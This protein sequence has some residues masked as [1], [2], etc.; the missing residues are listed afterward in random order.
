MALDWLELFDPFQV[1]LLIKIDIVIQQD[2]LSADN[3]VKRDAQ[4]A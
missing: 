3:H 4:D 1:N 2:R